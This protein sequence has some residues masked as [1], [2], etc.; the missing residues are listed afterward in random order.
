MFEFI[1]KTIPKQ[2]K[3]INNGNREYKI[4]LDIC[5]E[6]KTEIKKQKN[7]SQKHI[8]YLR[9]QK[10]IAKINKRATQLLYRLEE[11][12][13]KALYMIGIKDDGTVEG[14]TI[15]QLFT[16][17]N[18]LYKMVEIVNAFIKNIRIYKGIDEHKYICTIRI[19]NPNYKP[20]PLIII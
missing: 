1:N 5:G 8:D 17:I 2:K 3:E 7:K 19:I 15:E 4:F 16:S 10:L 12:H 9:Q 20:K 13:G 18:F 14:I 6:S 11:G